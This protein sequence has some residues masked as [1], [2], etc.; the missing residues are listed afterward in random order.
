MK[1]RVNMPFRW[2]LMLPISGILAACGGVDPMTESTQP[3]ENV[4]TATE[5]VIV[6]DGLADAYAVFKQSVQDIFFNPQF[7][8]D[9]H[10]GYGF[11]P[12]LSTE[13]LPGTEGELGQPPGGEVFFNFTA[14]TVSATLRGIPVG[15]N[16]D[17]WFVKNV[18]GSGRTVK[19][20]SGDILFKVGAL[21][22]STDPN[23]HCG[24]GTDCASIENLA[25]GNNFDFDL[26]MVVATRRGQ[27]PT[28][29][30]IA[31][32]ARG[33]LEKRFFRER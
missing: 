20:E 21:V 29:S 33:I 27:S 28:V 2:A 15:S 31:V 1:K 25:L 5:A 8:N 4:G 24:G 11:H 22:R 12:G 16:F 30:R 26:D 13:K 32:G 23:T 17:L 7:Q 14:R 3:I 9:Y 10:M 6:E 18:P 19:P